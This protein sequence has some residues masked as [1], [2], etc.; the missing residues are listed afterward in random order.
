MTLGVDVTRLQG[1]RTGVGRYV[2]YLLRAWAGQ[3]LPF[4]RLRLYSREHIPDLPTDGRLVS[5]VLPSRWGGIGWQLTQL[6]PA[7]RRESVL[8]SFYTLPPRGRPPSVLVNQGILV[9]AYAETAGVRAR[10][11][12]AH[13]GW[14]AR[15]ADL[16]V[17]HSQTTRD[18]LAHHF[19]VDKAKVRTLKPGLASIFRPGRLDRGPRPE[20]PYLL[21]VGKLAPR[22]HVPEVVEAFAGV[23]AAHP[24][25]RLLLVGPSSLDEGIETL[26]RRAGVERNVEHMPYVDLDDLARLYRGARAL[27]WPS[28]REGFG[29][30]ILEAMGCGCPVAVLD[31]A[32]LGVLDWAPDP[33]DRSAVL[34]IPSPE[35]DA[36]RET[37]LRLVADDALHSS[38]AERGY[39][40]AATFPTWEEHAAELMATISSFAKSDARWN[41]P[42]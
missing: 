27:V 18:D 7:V 21:F 29:H 34:G 3:P 19:G 30:P 8:L 22:R 39:A 9:G 5:A 14:S 26:A 12:A 42:A 20:R 35:A 4:K 38:L 23:V 2:E 25:Y 37:L 6:A 24:D 28:E 15:N 36:L 11:R 40:F 41:E 17:T 31:R 33:G 1:P 32:S 13:I 10:A 16:V